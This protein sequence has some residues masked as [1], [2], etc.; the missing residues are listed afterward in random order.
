MTILLDAPAELGLRRAAER[1]SADRM[2]SQELAFYQRVRAGY[3]T[4]AEMHPE[5]FAV[6][7]A[8]QSLK[9]VQLSIGQKMRRFFSN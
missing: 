6:V 3:L 2:D 7:D 8:S 9:R 4:L 1:G 5:R